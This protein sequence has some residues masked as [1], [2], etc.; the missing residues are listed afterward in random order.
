MNKSLV[1]IIVPYYKKKHFLKKTIN[2]ILKQTYKNYEII[3]IYD[4]VDKTDLAFIKNMLKKIKNVKIIVNQSNLGAGL[5]RNKG[6]KHSKGRFISFIDADDIWHKDK[7]K[8]QVL[9]MNKNRISFSFS[10]YH[11]INKYSKK[12][13][14]IVVP[15]KLTFKDLLFSCQIGLSTVMADS[16]LLKKVKFS[17]LK[18]QEDYLLWLKLS[19]KNITMLGVNESLSSWRKTDNSLSNSMRQKL[20]DAFQVYNK[21]LK[22]NYLITLI[23][24]LSL[25]IHSFK[26]R[27]L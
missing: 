14:T 1:S 13:K 15:K 4:D 10:N 20:R 25:S 12:L 5:S 18:T 3:L 11:I 17:N 21:H 23:L 16:G 2:S 6:I 7:L 9:F 19:K 27:F 22:L 8:K 24:I 26:K